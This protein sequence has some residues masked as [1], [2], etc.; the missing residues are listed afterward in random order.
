MKR[1]KSHCFQGFCN[2]GT[3]ALLRNCF[4]L[5]RQNIRKTG[6]FRSVLLFC[7]RM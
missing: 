4:I 3:M 5:G 7:E 1:K 2:F 6:C